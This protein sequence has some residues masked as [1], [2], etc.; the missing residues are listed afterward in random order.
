MGCMLD[1]YQCWIHKRNNII[2]THWSLMVALI[3]ALHSDGEPEI[4]PYFSLQWFCFS[5]PR[6]P[7]YLSIHSVTIVYLYI[8]IISWKHNL[9]L[10]DNMNSVCISVLY[11]SN[12][13][14]SWTTEHQTQPLDYSKKTGGNGSCTVTHLHTGNCSEWVHIHH[15]I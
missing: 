4:K 14:F 3:N 12:V 9:N 10:V 11:N 13:S 2:F 7:Y 1:F 8:V 15:Q 5:P 6:F